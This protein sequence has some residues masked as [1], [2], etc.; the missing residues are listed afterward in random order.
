MSLSAILLDEEYYEIMKSG[1]T[2][3]DNVTSRSEN[4][5]NSREEKSLNT[6]LSLLLLFFES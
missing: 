1:I 3:V 4:F 6:F 2:V 5:D